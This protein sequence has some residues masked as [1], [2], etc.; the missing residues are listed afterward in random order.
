M[1]AYPTKITEELARDLPRFDFLALWLT[2]VSRRRS[3]WGPLKQR[4]RRRRDGTF[5]IVQGDHD[6]VV[7]ATKDTS[8][9]FDYARRT[10]L[11]RAIR[12][13]E[14]FR[15]LAHDRAGLGFGPSYVAPTR[16]EIERDVASVL[17]EPEGSIVPI[18]TQIWNKM[19]G[20]ERAEVM[21]AVGITLGNPHAPRGVAALR[22]CA[23]HI[24]DHLDRYRHVLSR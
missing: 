9:L 24:R 15:V 12:D 1:A 6:V 19:G 16:D 21:R 10:Q 13:A 8:K 17:T 4:V 20:D 3:S 2:V 22:A 7:Y 11:G 5:E 23:R 18:E 14:E